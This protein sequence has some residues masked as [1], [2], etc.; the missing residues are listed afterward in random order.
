MPSIDPWMVA[1]AVGLLN[2]AVTIY[3]VGWRI[4]ARFA[5][6]EVKVATMWEFMLKRA[7]AETFTKGIATTHSPVQLTEAAQ[8]A[9]APISEDLKRWYAREGARLPYPDMMLAL[10][11][12]FG[13][14]L[15]K[16]VC[17]PLGLTDGACLVAA[18]LLC[19]VRL[20]R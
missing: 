10:E 15:M 9:L 1:V 7:F 8:Q 2:T 3:V 20:R 17:I 12:R 11:R 5:A 18:A 4:A 16:H 13:T 6:L 19:G 14:W